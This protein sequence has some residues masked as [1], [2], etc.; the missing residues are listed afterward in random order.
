MGRTQKTIADT[1]A[2]EFKLPHKTA[3]HFVQRVFDLIIEDI[4]YSGGTQLRG[5][6]TFKTYV[7]KGHKIKLPKTGQTIYVQ[8]KKTVR[9]RVSKELTDKLNP[10]LPLL[11]DDLQAKD[12]TD[13]QGKPVAGG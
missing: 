7:R 1:L 11:A 3:R 9:Y 4:E 6:G 13:G 10:K 2:R 8:D 12:V 5:L